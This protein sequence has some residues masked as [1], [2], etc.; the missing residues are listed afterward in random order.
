MKPAGKSSG[1]EQR[2]D[3]INRHVG[4][5]LRIARKALNLSQE[6]LA[7]R[8][9]IT[10]QQVQKYENGISRISASRL[11]QAALILDVPVSFFFPEVEP[12][13]APTGMSEPSRL[14]CVMD[15]LGNRE[16]IELNVA[17]SKISDLK[18]RRQL[19]QLVQ[20]IAASS[21]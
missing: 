10:F 2:S 13:S 5:R 12:A 15:W 18:V 16:G 11:H 19:V 14:G 3:L 4:S 21:D 7:G 8:L 20:S 6:A 1:R 9:G 17:F